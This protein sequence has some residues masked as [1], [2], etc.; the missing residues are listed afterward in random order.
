METNAREVDKLAKKLTFDAREVHEL[1]GLA[2]STIFEKSRTGEIPGAIR[3]GRRLLFSRAKIMAWLDGQSE[4]R[5][6]D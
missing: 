3:V 1:S 5:E 2:L 4:E 6:G